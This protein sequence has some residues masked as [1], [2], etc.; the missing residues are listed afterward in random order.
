MSR[1]CSPSSGRPYGLARTCR[2]LE[3]ARSTIYARRARRSRP[4]PL[5]KP[6][7]KPAWTDAEL[8]EQIRVA[9]AEAPFVGEGYRE[10][11]GASAPGWYPDQSSARVAADASRRA[12]G[13]DAPGPCPWPGRP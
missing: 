12:A 13:T 5:H 7:P 4:I 3:I 2:V 10:G 9:L 8:I 11:L 1:A 6:G